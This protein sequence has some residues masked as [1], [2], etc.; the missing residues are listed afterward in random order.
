MTIRIAPCLA[1]AALSAVGGCATGGEGGSRPR[2]PANSCSAAPGQTFIGR[3]ASATVG[4]ELLA[5]THAHELRW[6]P[7][8][9]AITMEYKFGRLTVAY[10][11]A[12]AI[13]SVSCS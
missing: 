11:D 10:D 1:L 4:A 5:A 6:V 2:P 7:P 3:T 13:V 8:R 9:S 12:Y